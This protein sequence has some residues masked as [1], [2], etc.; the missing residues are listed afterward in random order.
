MR[1]KKE[2]FLNLIADATD[3]GGMFQ[4]A[5]CLSATPTLSL[6]SARF[7]YLRSLAD[8]M[9]I[10]CD[11]VI[12]ALDAIKLGRKDAS[13]AMQWLEFVEQTLTA[14]AIPFTAV[15]KSAFTNGE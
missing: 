9:S 10:H 5:L 4:Y 14:K 7:Y 15:N 3:Y 12:G 11:A 2:E 13:E 1:R 8:L 6:E